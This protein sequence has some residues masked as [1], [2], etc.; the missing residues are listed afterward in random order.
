MDSDLV[1]TA[2]VPYCL[3]R[4]EKNRVDKSFQTSMKEP[5]NHHYTQYAVKPYCWLELKSLT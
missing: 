3:G 2:D 1:G 4:R 5:G